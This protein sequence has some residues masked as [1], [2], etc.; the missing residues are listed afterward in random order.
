MEVFRPH[1]IHATG[2]NGSPP[3]PGS[4]TYLL[5]DI[6]NTTEQCLPT[7]VQNGSPEGYYDLWY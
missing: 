6:R 4:E 2:L 3:T 1:S 7:E 5:G